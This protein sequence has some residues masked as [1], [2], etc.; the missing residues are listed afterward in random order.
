MNVF[1]FDNTIYDG[2]SSVDFFLWYIKKDPSLIKFI[3]SVAV[4]LF[5]YKTGKLTVEKALSQ[6]GT[7][8]TAYFKEKLSGENTLSA[9]ARI[10][11]K[12][13]A[14]NLK[15]IFKSSFSSDDVIISCSPR[16][17]LEEPLNMLGIK[18]C[19]CSEIDETTGEIT[20]L[21]FR[22]NKVKA[23]FNEY[24]Q[25]EIDNFYTDSFNDKPLMDISKNVFLVKGSEI[26]KIK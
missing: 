9:D 3:P 25:C 14:A 2:E 21:C 26:K 7:K 6:Y 15:P 5:K 12:A 10:F 19:I 13:H 4:A 24:P 17:L 18:K 11:W 23:F 1:D 8:L 22:E 16:F 20:R